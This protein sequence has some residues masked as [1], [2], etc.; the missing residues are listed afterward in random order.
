M[1]II[2]LSGNLIGVSLVILSMGCSA[3]PVAE[4][5]SDGPT[6]HPLVT[7][8]PVLSVTPRPPT[9]VPTSTPLLIPVTALPLSIP[10]MQALII[11]VWENTRDGEPYRATFRFESDGTTI[12]AVSAENGGG[13]TYR[14]LDS[15]RIETTMG[16]LSGKPITRQW[17]IGF[18]PDGLY[19]VI[20]SVGNKPE[21]IELTRIR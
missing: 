13:G 7:P 19:L 3:T 16:P 4:I 15:S 21:R 5:P 12:W 17:D 9:Q 18:S 8:Q 20:R 2:K 6:A 14:F 1:R 11:G 10:Q